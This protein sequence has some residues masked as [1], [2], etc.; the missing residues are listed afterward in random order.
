MGLPHVDCSEVYVE[1]NLPAKKLANIAFHEL[2]HNK[3][4]TG[5]RRVP[6]IHTLGGIGLSPTNEQSKLTG[7]NKQLMAQHMFKPVRQYTGAM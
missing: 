6:N 4:D 7:P 1:H 3:L 5:A 2:M